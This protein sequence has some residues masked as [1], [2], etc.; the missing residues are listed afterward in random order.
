MSNRLTQ[1]FIAGLLGAVILTVIMFIMQAAGMSDPGF[2][3]MYRS[4]FGTN[5]PTDQIIAALLF[6]I[7][8]GIWGLL[9]GLIT[10]EPSV[11]KGMLFGILPTLWL[12]IVVNA[13][14]G[15]PLFNGFT[16]KGLIMPF[17]FNVIIWGSFVGWYM[18]NRQHSAH[19]AVE[20]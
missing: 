13:F 11:L 18:S 8:G 19:P 2:V 17:I 3:S 15:K 9:F 1:G 6:I 7:S 16:A 20:V 10:K 14:L 12:W 4:T 5:P